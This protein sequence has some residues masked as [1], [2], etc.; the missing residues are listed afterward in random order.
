M[1]TWCADAAPT[2]CWLPTRHCNPCEA[3]NHWII[4]DPSRSVGYY[5]PD[6][7]LVIDASLARGWYRS[8]I[9]GAEDIAFHRPE[10]NHCQTSRPMWFD[11]ENVLYLEISPLQVYY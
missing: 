5:H 11:G 9:P 6:L 3:E 7:D 2:D 10:E 4:D 1:T 8:L